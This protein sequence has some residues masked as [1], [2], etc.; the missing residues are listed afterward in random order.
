VSEIVYDFGT[1]AHFI[2]CAKAMGLWREP[3]NDEPGGPIQYGNGWFMNVSGPVAFQTGATTTDD[4]GQTIPVMELRGYWARL[5]W[6]RDDPIPPT[7]PGVTE[8][9]DP[10]IQPPVAMIA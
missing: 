1:E 6:L 10:A 3:T 4:A 9:T 2:D 5:R 8:Y 7:P